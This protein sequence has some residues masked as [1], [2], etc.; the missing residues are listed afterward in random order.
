MLLEMVLVAVPLGARAVA[1]DP[2]VLP[3][4]DAPGAF[5][6][7]PCAACCLCLYASYTALICEASLLEE[8]LALRGL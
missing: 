3:A 2:D 6:S 1:G 4:L 7:K 8:L 5:W